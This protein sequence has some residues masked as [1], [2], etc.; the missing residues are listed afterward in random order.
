MIK[1]VSGVKNIIKY[2]NTL[3]LKRNEL[4]YEIDG[5]VFKLNNYIEREKAGSRS[6]SPRWAIAGKFKAQQVT[7]EIVSISVQVGR[8]GAL[9]PVAKVKPVY[10]SGVTVTNITLHN[11]DEIERKDIRIGDSV[12]IERSGDVIPKIV[13]VVKR[14]NKSPK[15]KIESSCPSCHEPS[16][17]MEG[18]AVT[19]CINSNCPAQF[20]GKI[21]HFCSK[22]AMN[23][24]GLGE[25][26]IEQLIE[27]GLIKK[28]DNIYSIKEN[29]IAKLDRMGEKSAQNIIQSI[30]L[31]KK[32]TFAK[33]IYALGIRNVGEHTAKTLEKY[34]NSNL[35]NFMNATENQ[36][37]EIEEIGEI[38][39]Q[40]II[41][42]WEDESNI[43]AVNNCIQNGVQLL[44]PKINT[45]EHLNN[46]IFAFTGTLELMNRNDAKKKVENA[47]GLTKN[48]LTKKTTHLVAGQK[49]GSKVEKAKKM[50]II[51]LSENEFVELLNNN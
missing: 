34:Y 22:L 8:T 18:D 4:N 39:A 44:K 35:E 3:E 46:T 42:F 21:Q 19:R 12:L 9:T 43:C 31:S 11:Q 10:V 29:E 25:K 24:E 14:N 36:L 6:R 15:Y 30:N 23:I 28:L 33:F 45:S 37:I 48:S 7:T 38:V 40:S 49:T 50:G 51:I 16:I 13:K 5:T 41:I 20:K 26:I 1:K 32:T 27:N 47:G 2:H 17:K